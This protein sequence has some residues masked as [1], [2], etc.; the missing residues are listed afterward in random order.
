MATF[1]VILGEDVK[2]EGLHV[3][4]ESLVVQEELGQQT[5]VLTVDCAHIPVNLGW[6][7]RQKGQPLTA[8]A[9]EVH[10]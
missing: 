5:Q 3:V 7:E 9:P 8:L 1:A 6:N 10:A 2:K 4:V